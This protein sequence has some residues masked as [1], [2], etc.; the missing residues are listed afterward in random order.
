MLPNYS[1]QGFW[2]FVR[3]KYHADYVVV[4]AKNYKN[5]IS[6]GQVLQ[7]AN[8][9]KIRGAGMFAI[10]I[11]RSGADNGAQLTVREQWMANQKMIVVLNDADIE[12]MLL[13]KSAGGDPSKV[14]GQAIEQLRLSM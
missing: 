13:A 9:L 4:D 6:K 12:A 2:R 8:Y 3:E 1:Y 10:I 14:I 5:P 11:T 7:I